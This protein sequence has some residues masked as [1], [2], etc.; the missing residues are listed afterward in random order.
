MGSVTAYFLWDSRSLLISQNGT[1]EQN[2]ACQVCPAA[3][4]SERIKI[5]VNETYLMTNS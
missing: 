2:L 5:H 1:F 4:S 3:N